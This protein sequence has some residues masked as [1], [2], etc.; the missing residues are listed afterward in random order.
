[1]DS[2]QSG[3]VIEC[4]IT[5]KN[6]K[7]REFMFLEDPIPSNCHVTEQTDLEEGTEWSFWFS[8]MQILEDRVGVFARTLVAGEQKI[9]YHL[10][11]ESPG[12][13]H[14]LPTRLNGM[15]NPGKGSFS[16]EGPMEVRK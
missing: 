12:L 3:D 9:V 7:P 14:A 4:E 15:Y 1:M 8:G 10:R 16:A 2:A 11:A 13:S 6:D 5:I